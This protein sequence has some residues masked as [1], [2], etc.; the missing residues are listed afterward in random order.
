VTTQL[1]IALL[2]CWTG[3]KAGLWG[4]KPLM[5]IAFGALLIRGIFYTLTNNTDVLMALQIL[6]GVAS[7]IFGV[8]IS[9]S[10][11]IAGSIVHH[12]GATTGFMFLASV[13]SVALGTLFFYAG[14]AR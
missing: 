2:A 11:V 1:V 8:G 14:D 13:A 4:R 12:Y 6:D 3:Q 10:Q 5:L 7:G 9:L